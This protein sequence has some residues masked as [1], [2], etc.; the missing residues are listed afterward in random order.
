MIVSEYSFNT[1][2]EAK[3]ILD[4]TQVVSLLSQL[5]NVRVGGSYFTDLMYDPDIDIS[6]ATSNPRESALAFLN[7]VIATRTFQKY[8]YGDFEKYLLQN[9]P[10]AHI[11]V[12]ILPFNERRWEIE[13]WFVT[14]H[15]KDQVELEEKLQ[16]LP[17]ETKTKI[18]EQK[19][20]R[21]ESGQGK[22]SRPSIEIYQKYV[23]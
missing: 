15:A 3:K 9:R 11:V 20:K 7:Q 1:C 10:H 6:V 14:K 16:Q 19:A 22:H 23:G 5:G 12:L 8:Q 4:N 17:L 21:H 2:L 18:L 13:I